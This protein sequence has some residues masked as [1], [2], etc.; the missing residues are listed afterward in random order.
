[1]KLISELLKRVDILCGDY[2]NTIK[3]ADINTF[4]YFDPPYKPISKT[5]NFVSY[6]KDVFNDNEQIRLSNFL[7]KIN[8]NNAQF[9]LS[10]S[11]SKDNYKNNIFLYEIYKGF[12]IYKVKAN[13]N[14]NCKAEK[15]GKINELL[16]TNYFVNKKDNN[17]SIYYI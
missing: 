11:H 16:I 8:K 10:N 14:I 2:T 1:M 12:N 15:R 3:Y 7:H 4:Y 5:S 17:L 6:S 9:M 13:R